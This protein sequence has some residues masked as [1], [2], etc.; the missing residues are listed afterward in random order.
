MIRVIGGYAMTSEVALLNR[1]AIALAADSATTV[2]YWDKGGPKRRF[3]KGANKIFNISS[4]HP[5]GLMTFASAN[6]QGVPWELVTKS[7]RQYLEDRSHDHLH[8]Y[9]TDFFDFA[10]NHA[11]MFPREVQEKQFKVQA[12][13][14]AT[15]VVQSIIK[16]AAYTTEADAAK[17]EQFLRGKLND[18]EA[19]VRAAKF[20]ANADQADVDGAIARFSSEV[21]AEFRAD[22][23]FQRFVISKD[24]C[25]TVAL[26]SWR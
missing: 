18:R 17:K 16:D 23:Y 24:L 5:V 19:A 1:N 25:L 6:L 14:A 2:T 3:F 21:V 26:V 10:A 13:R 20:I 22:V 9:A 8:E 4:L 7:Y 12:D 15:P 11:L